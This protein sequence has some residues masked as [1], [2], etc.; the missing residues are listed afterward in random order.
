MGGGGGGRVDL[1]VRAAAAVVVLEGCVYRPVA[2]V[3]RTADSR[4]GDE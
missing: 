3:G 1:A 2:E 4:A